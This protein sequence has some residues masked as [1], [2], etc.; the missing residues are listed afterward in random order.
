MWNQTWPSPAL[1]LPIVLTESQLLSVASVALN[2][3]AQ[4]LSPLP[5]LS[6]RAKIV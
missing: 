6:S 2:E 5:C 3:A 1:E 4:P